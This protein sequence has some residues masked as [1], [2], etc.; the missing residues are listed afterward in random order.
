MRVLVTGGAG[1]IGAHI[2]A[3]LVA[4]GDTVAVLDDLSAGRRERVPND[5]TFHLADVRDAP[6]VE[7]I[8][9]Q[10]A[11]DAVCHQ[12]AQTSVPASFTDPAHDADVNLRGGLVVLQAVRRHGIARFVHASSGGA[13][14]GEVAGDRVASVVDPPSP[15][16]P[17]GW[18]KLAFEGAAAA[19]TAGDA[20]TV[21]ALRYANVYGP[22]QTAEGEAGVVAIFARALADDR[23]VTIF[24]RRRA[25]DDGCVRDYVFVDD[26][27]RINLAALDGEVTTACVDVATGV[28]TTT[29]DLA[30][31]L[32]EAAGRSLRTRAGAPRAGDVERSVI[33]SGPLVDVIGPVTGLRAGL[34]RTLAG[35]SDG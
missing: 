20:I 32:G 31:A 19:L 28:G 15:A 29:R 1:F 4:R 12:A 13:V 18:S 5:A 9:A 26:V 24:G 8:V 34:L 2:T 6:A 22:G 35:L 23:E 25:G 16:T 27:V 30:A 21:V 14:Y 17:Y 3:A 7:R 11:P 10:F 33:A